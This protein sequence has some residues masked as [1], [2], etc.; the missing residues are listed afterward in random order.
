MA[1]RH[2][3]G[4]ALAL[5]L[6]AY[7]MALAAQQ[8]GGAEDKVVA[9]V[10]GEEIRQ[11]DVTA[12]ARTLPPQYQSQVE[13]IK[14]LLVDRLVDFK[15]AGMAGRDAGLASDER[16][17]AF[18]AKAEEQAIRELYLER[19]IE[20]RITDEL[21]QEA[22]QVHLADN[23][24]AEEFHA[25]HILV[26]TEEA[27]RE[28]IGLLD[29]G[30]DFAELAKERSTGPSGPRGGDLGYFTADQMVPEFSQAAA[31]L[32]PGSYTKEPAKTQFGWH[33]I[34]LEDRRTAAPPP[35]EELEQ[36]LREQVA[37]EILGTV[38]NGLRDGAEIEIV[39]ESAEPAGEAAPEPAPEPAPAQ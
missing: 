12:M 39:S 28:V 14:H 36:Q 31:A 7:P 1:F 11:S 9:R 33:V 22:Y 6:A 32:E 35:L 30:A 21:I 2:L 8:S 29:D 19:E 34:K 18:V 24:P 16:V 38:L 37:R 25:R 10:N 20:A 27:A 15:L 4:A 13:Q 26:E 17:K 23:P 5:A 3:F